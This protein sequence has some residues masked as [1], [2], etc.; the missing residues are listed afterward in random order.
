VALSGCNLGVFVTQQQLTDT[1]EMSGLEAFT[2]LEG[3][4]TESPL[5]GPTSGGLGPQLVGF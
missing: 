5:E 1:R 2:M 3:L 4:D